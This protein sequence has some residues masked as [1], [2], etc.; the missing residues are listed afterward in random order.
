MDTSLLPATTESLRIMLLLTVI[1]ESKDSEMLFSPLNQEI[2]SQ[3]NHH[4]L[5]TPGTS[6]SV[7]GDKAWMVNS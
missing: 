2:C 6:Q 3:L 4:T 1:L 5:K 7:A